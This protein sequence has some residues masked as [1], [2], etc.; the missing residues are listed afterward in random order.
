VISGLVVEH[1]VTRSVRDSARCLDAV[2]GAMPGDPYAAPDPARPFAEELTA[3]PGRLRIGLRTAAPGGQFETHADCIEAAEAAAK[4]LE[5]LGH[6]VE[7]AAPEALD[8]P[9][10][11]PTF[12][13]RWTAGVAWNLRYWEAQTGDEIGPDDVEPTTWALAEAGRGHSAPDYLRAL[14]FHQKLT[15]RVAAWWEQG[16]DLLLTPTTGEPATVLGEFD[17]PA[18]NPVAPLM[19]AIPLGAFTAGLNTTGQPAISL[20]LHWRAD[21]LIRVASQLEQAAPWADRWPA[22]AERA[23]AA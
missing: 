15:R 4:L 3:G 22:V 17:A 10:Y 5:G 2:A 18:D 6:D 14:E 9:D 16:Y 8:D 1:V 20:P 12:L 13:L 19:R 23:V 7:Q 11:I 21:V